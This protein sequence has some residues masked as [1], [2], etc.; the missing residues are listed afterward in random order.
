MR[1]Y[2]EQFTLLGVDDHTGQL[3]RKKPA[4]KRVTGILRIYSDCSGVDDGARNRDRTGTALRP[5]D[6]K[7]LVSTYFTI[8]AFIIQQLT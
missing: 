5:R 2:V 6:F 1:Q 4:F 3:R 7:S 8:R